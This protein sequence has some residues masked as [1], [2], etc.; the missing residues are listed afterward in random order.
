LTQLREFLEITHNDTHLIEVLALQALSQKMAGD[1]SAAM[2]L[3]RQALVL[4]LPGHFVRI[5]LDLGP[6]AGAFLQRLPLDDPELDNYRNKI[7]AAMLAKTGQVLSSVDRD[8]GGQLL[9]EPLTNR[10]LEILSLLVQRQTDKEI[11]AHLH[12]SPH[13]VRTHTKNIYAKLGVNSRR[14]AALRA[15]ELGLKP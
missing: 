7:T 9:V 4:G 15:I 3:L 2:E 6:A 1:D 12:I 8:N 14:Q 5:F 11:A 13:T 10:E